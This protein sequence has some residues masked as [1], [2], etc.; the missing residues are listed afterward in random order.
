MIDALRMY[1]Y[2]DFINNLEKFFIAF[3]FLFL[4]NSFYLENNILQATTKVY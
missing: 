2:L 4:P 3:H 1:K